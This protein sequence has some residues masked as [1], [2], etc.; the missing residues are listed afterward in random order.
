MRQII[1]RQDDAAPVDTISV[2]GLWGYLLYGGAF[3]NGHFKLFASQASMEQRCS[4]LAQ[5][6]MRFAALDLVNLNPIAGSHARVYEGMEQGPAA[7]QGFRHYQSRSMRLHRCP[8]A[9]ADIAGDCRPRDR[10]KSEK[11]LWIGY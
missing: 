1:C 10:N 2:S 8:M 4:C 11:V 7:S 5:E 9:N 6:G 3:D